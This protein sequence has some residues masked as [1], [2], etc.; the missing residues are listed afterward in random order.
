MKIRV[1]YETDRKEVIVLGRVE[2]RE[3]D[4]IGS[5]VL[6]FE[7]LKLLVLTVH[8]DVEELRVYVEGVSRY[9]VDGWTGYIFKLKDLF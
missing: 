7:F 6:A 3:F 1:E 9:S 2:G 5:S 8:M 4:G